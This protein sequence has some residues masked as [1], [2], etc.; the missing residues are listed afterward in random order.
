VNGYDELVREYFKSLVNRFNLNDKL[1]TATSYGIS[2]QSKVN[3]LFR[4]VP[5]EWFRLPSKE[6]AIARG[7]EVIMECSFMSAKAHVFT[8]SPF[9]GTL[10][11]SEILKLSLGTIAN[12]AMFYGSL[13]AVMRYLGLIDRT[14]HCRG[15]EPIK[16]AEALACEVV[17]RFGDVPTLLIGYQPAMA[18]SLDSVLSKLYI[19]DMNP[20]NIGKRI[21]NSMVMSHI[22]NFRLLEEVEIAIVTGSSVVNS[23]LW[24]IYDKAKKLS[25]K[26]MVYGVTAAGVAKIL[27]IERYCKFGS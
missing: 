8:S 15:E 21:G 3:V 20:C 25:V 11:L 14:L 16:C 23:T 22:E 27:N 2:S 19:T 26:L 6:Y 4:T 1:V 12:R 17:D 13:N 24:P 7:K 10:S 18:R 5:P 9:I